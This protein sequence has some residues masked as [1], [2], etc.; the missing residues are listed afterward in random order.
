MRNHKRDLA[1]VQKAA[2]EAQG[3]LVQS[4]LLYLRSIVGA[5]GLTRYTVRC[6]GTEEA[7]ER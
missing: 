4:L 3:E 1:D 5:N 7:V 6:R 2:D